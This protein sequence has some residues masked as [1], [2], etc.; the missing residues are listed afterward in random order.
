MYDIAGDPYLLSD[1]AAV[2]T[3]PTD[4]SDRMVSAI[5]Q[6]NPDEPTD[7][8]MPVSNWLI[9][10]DGVCGEFTQSNNNAHWIFMVVEADSRL[11]FENCLI[12][13]FRMHSA[14]FVFIVDG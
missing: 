7:Y 2:G 8:Y 12:T 5:P 14:A 11:N 1:N 13:E 4:D 6:T 9:N 10:T 3:R